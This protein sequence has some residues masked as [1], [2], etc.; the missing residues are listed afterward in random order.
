[1]HKYRHLYG[2]CTFCLT[3]IYICFL[4]SGLARVPGTVF[5]MWDHRAFASVLSLPATS[6]SS[7]EGLSPQS[8]RT[9][10]TY[11]S[12]CR[13]FAS[14]SHRLSLPISLVTEGFCLSPTGLSLPISSTARLSPQ[15]HRT[16]FTYL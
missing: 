14:Q 9:V 12:L 8:C 2:A 1:M 6:V 5:S 11:L 4:T 13:A 10:F 7:P 15:C 3:C 16:V